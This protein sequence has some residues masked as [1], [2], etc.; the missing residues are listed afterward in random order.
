MDG[1]EVKVGDLVK[2]RK[3]QEVMSALEDEAVTKWALMLS[4][5]ASVFRMLGYEAGTSCTGVLEMFYGV[6][7]L[8][9][10]FHYLWKVWVLCLVWKSRN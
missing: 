3:Y 10:D 5:N 2:E 6:V 8:L 9:W 4:L 7:S 1:G